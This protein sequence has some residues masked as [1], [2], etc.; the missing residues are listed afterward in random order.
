MKR[1]F[2][3]MA[4]SLCAIVCLFAQQTFVIDGSVDPEITDSCYN[5]YIS[6]DYFH[7]DES[8]VD[9]CVPVVDKK[10]RIEIPCDKVKAA[11]IRCIFPGGEVCSACIDF[12]VVPGETYSF[13]V[14][15]GHFGGQPTRKY[16][17]NI[18]R[19]VVAART[20]NPSL[21]TPHTPKFKGKK[22]QTVTQD[23][24][25]PLIYVK[26]VIFGKDET[27]LHIMSDFYL[28]NIFIGKEVH[29]EDE[30][31][32]KYEI[33]R[34]EIANLDGNCTPEMR[35]Y[36]GYLVFKPVAEGTKCINFFVGSSEKPTIANIK[37]NAKKQKPNFKLNVNVSPDI[38]DNGYL[39]YMYDK[40]E[41]YYT[42]QSE[43]AVKDK[44]ASYNMCLDEKRLAQLFATFPDGSICQY[45][46]RFPFVPG[47]ECELTVKNG[48][49]YLSGSEFYRQWGEADLYIENLKGD[50]RKELATKYFKEHNTEKGCIS[51]YETNGILPLDSIVNML[52]ESIIVSEFGIQLLE[53]A[54]EKEAQRRYYEEK[55]RKAKE[56]Q[57]NTQPGMKFV[58]FSVEYDGK[59]QRLSDYVGKG[60]Y[61]LV[62]FWAS[63]CGPCREEIPNIKKVWEKYKGVKFEVLGV[64]SMDKP[65]DTFMA[66]EQLGIEYPQIINARE[67]VLDAYGIMGIPTIILFGPDGT[68]IDRDLRGPAI[69]EAVRKCMEKDSS[70]K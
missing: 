27:V 10:F 25:N 33:V 57:K 16:M 46:M 24:Q 63:W 31:G 59:V 7:I 29:I 54:H 2:F 34:A 56:K 45:C 20:A 8:K 52:P 47:E 65:K 60:K 70:S 40:K 22:W 3:T 61:V 50:Q 68:I 42:L 32:N 55:E 23:A 39:I 18:E 67:E 14:H 38:T 30:H 15:N 13:E 21:V 41:R 6:D 37:E 12:F 17:Q 48:C 4:L 35:V 49:F 51:F 1:I 62:D 9:M 58:D 69:M 36:G 43:I 11:R 26:D 53:K 64:A 19:G 44:K 28:S 66:V 5:V